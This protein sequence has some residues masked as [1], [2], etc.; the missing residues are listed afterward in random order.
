MLSA[1]VGGK[2]ISRMSLGTVQLGMNYG[3]SNT[4][5]QP[6]EKRSFAMLASAL[7]NGV[8]SVDTA[9]VYGNS[10]EVLGHFFAQYKGQLPYI[11]TKIPDLETEDAKG[12]EK[13][14]ISYVETSLE[15]L[16]LKKVD[17]IMLH[18]AK[19]LIRDGDK[20]A[21]VME[22]LIRRGYT[23]AVGVSVYTGEDIDRMLQYDVY[24]TTQVPMS[25]FDQRLIQHGYLAR[26]Q[27]RGVTV[28]VRSVFLQG[29]F[30]MD[31]ER[32]TDRQLIECA[33]EPIRKIREYADREEMTVAELAIA[34]IRD[35]V[36][37]SSLV[38]G[39]DTEDQVKSNVKYFETRRISERTLSDITKTFAAVDIPRIMEVL[40]R[41]KS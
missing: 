31:P 8:N 7:E 28:F 26:L 10:E 19:D 5:G 3:I 34:F 9:R 27:E 12:I 4:L 22:S 32:F 37:V 6:D 39:A 15:K 38:L 1:T 40:S 17:N 21:P 23:D 11:T 41:P 14:M 2:S 29:L 35:L 30:F 18:A 16:G 13:E 24:T 20:I 25:I 36:G 33:S